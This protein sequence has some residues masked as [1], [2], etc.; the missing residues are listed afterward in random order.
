MGRAS[1]LQDDLS[2]RAHSRRL[3]SEG[4]EERVVSYK[5][6]THLIVADPHSAKVRQR[7]IG[8]VGK[9][10]GGLSLD[11][12]AVGRLILWKFS[13]QVQLP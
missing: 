6:S 9:V 10:K 7:A 11:F 1:R 3:V 4:G 2:R 5:A 12:V 13:F 8:Q